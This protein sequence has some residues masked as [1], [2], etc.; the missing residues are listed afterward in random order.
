MN[1]MDRLLLA[2]LSA[3]LSADVDVSVCE[4]ETLPFTDDKV[5][6][7]GVD[8][9]PLASDKFAICLSGPAETLI[10]DGKMAE[11]AEDTLGRLEVLRDKLLDEEVR[12]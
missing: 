6:G 8:I 12:E 3:A 10:S 2:L 11:L 4:Y 9:C 1:T 7:W 5:K